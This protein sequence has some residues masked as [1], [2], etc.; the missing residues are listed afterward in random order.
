MRCLRKFIILKIAVIV[1]TLKDVMMY[2]NAKE[3]DF[4]PSAYLM[5]IGS[6]YYCLIWLAVRQHI[7]GKNSIIQQTPGFVKKLGLELP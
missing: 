2:W 1:T 4:M 3:F 7:P 6:T 5:L